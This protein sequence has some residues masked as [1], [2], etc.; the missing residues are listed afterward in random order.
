[1]SRRCA[2]SFLY[3]MFS[4]WRVCRITLGMDFSEA[5]PLTRFDPSEYVVNSK[6]KVHKQATLLEM[7]SIKSSGHVLNLH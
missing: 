4:L 6:L 7:Q 3:S 1:M 2:R 5:Y